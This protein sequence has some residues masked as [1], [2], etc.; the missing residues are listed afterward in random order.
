MSYRELAKFPISFP[1]KGAGG[2]TG[3]WR[4]SK[5]VINTDLCV[6]CGLCGLYCPTSSITLDIKSKVIGINYEYCKGCGICYSLCPRKAI[7]MVE[8]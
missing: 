5:P 8:E 2:K 3:A 4:I 7:I 6:Y 1:K